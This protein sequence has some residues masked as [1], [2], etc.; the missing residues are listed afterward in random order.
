MDCISTNL[1]YGDTGYFSRVAIDYVS[2][3]DDL[4]S[5]YRH[6]VSL[7][8]ISNAIE[9]RKKS[10]VDRALLV[11]ELTRQYEGI[12]HSD[13][14][15]DNIRLLL[16]EN[17]F[18]VC[19]AHQPAIF[20]GSLF[21]IYKILHIIKLC[22]HFRESFP[23]YDF[24]PV[25]YMGCE[26]ADLDELGNIALNG[27]KLTWDT[28]QTGAVGRMQPK[29]LEK[30]IE[31]I[32]GE[33][34]VQPFG[35]ALIELLKDCYNN[36][37]NIQIAT[38]K[39]V[40][41]LFE[42]YGLLVLIPDNAALK[43]PLTPVFEQELFEETSSA[44]VAR[45]IERFSKQYKAQAR[46]RA[47][48]LFYLDEQVRARI[49]RQG[50]T[51]IV[52]GT[53]I[54]FTEASLR[55]ELEEHPERFSPNV[56][57]RGLSQEKILPNIGFVGG[58]GELAYWL[59]LKDLFDHYQTPYP[60]L[61]LRNSF[62]VMDEQ[63]LKKMEALGFDL[64]SLFK[65]EQTL[66]NEL[67]KRE[68]SHQLSLIAEIQNASSYYEQLKR[69]AAQVDPSLT[70]HISALQARAIKP[71][72]ELEKKLL[73]AEKR[74]FEAQHRQIQAMK[75]ALFPWDGLQERVENFMPFYA[76]WGQDFIRML[77]AESL[78]L[79]Q[80]FRVVAVKEQQT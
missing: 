66:V 24:V 27:E 70:D 43:R 75:N 15:R 2:Q 30:I 7:D 45:T 58:G 33:L 65:D 39:L 48:N 16:N 42:E 49:E 22:A 62:L 51:W 32:S 41:R 4:R 55:Q 28:S 29:G 1:A 31:R 53:D 9:D 6:P 76:R 72:Q 36:S 11:K 20:T 71:L 25:F 80:V 21:F 17:A 52:A 67:V 23:R 40:N 47:I 8:G 46:P 3:A 14:V 35:P 74:K 63:W 69:I 18:T 64:A 73:R 19:T 57:L 60:A 12:P 34:S 54:S 50:E 56:I 78:T 13:K 5:F 10:P 44:I 68:S 77:Y 61:I 26:D 37:P 79:E 38:L 59:E